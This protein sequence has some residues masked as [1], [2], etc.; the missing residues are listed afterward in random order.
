MTLATSNL[1]GSWESST[2]PFTSKYGVFSGTGITNKYGVIQD[3]Y[4]S[5][6]PPPPPGNRLLLESGILWN[7]AGTVKVGT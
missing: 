3:P 1:Y 4:G 7:D 6:T 2:P 5:G